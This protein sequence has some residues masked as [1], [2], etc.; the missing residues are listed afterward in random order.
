MNIQIIIFVIGLIVMIMVVAGLYA[1][2]PKEISPPDKVFY[3]KDG[4][5]IGS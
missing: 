2:V 3:R 1:L 5:V 4:E